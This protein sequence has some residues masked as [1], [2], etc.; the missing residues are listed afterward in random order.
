MKI[1]VLGC[2]GPY[3][4]IGGATSGYLLQDGEKSFLLDLGSGVFARL[5]EHMDPVR[6]S[7][8]ILTHLHFDHCSDLGVL[9]YYCQVKRKKGWSGKLACYLPAVEQELIEYQRQYDS[10]SLLP[11]RAGELVLDGIPFRFYLMRHP[12]PCLGLTVG[13]F[14]YTGDTN[15][16][17]GLRELL[18][19]CNIALM[20]GGFLQQDYSEAFPHMHAAL[21]ESL[22]LSY[23]VKPY[24]THISPQYTKEELE[25]ECHGTAQIVQ[26]GMVI[27]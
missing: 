11:L 27:L 1:T 8:V 14:G 23:G 3:P 21:A 4:A 19:N 9:N 17:D 25:R 20:D 6:L 5:C 10:L 12:V 13:T 18:Q 2:N 26:Q 15:V 24:I 7:A 16:C 22:A